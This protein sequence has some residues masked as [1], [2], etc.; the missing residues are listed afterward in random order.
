MKR[1]PADRAD[2]HVSAQVAAALAHLDATS[3]AGELA[4]A[5][6]EQDRVF[7]GAM[8]ELQAVRD[9][10]GSPENILGRAATKHGEIGCPFTPREHG[11]LGG[12]G[13]PMQVL[14]EMRG[15]QGVDPRAERNQAALG[16]LLARAP[17]S[18]RPPGRSR[19]PCHPS[20]RSHV[21]RLFTL[22]DPDRGT[23]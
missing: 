22:I 18:K 17:H 2:L 12:E 15:E 19:R 8:R 20:H 10:V 16:E 3:R 5:L 4:G 13:L 1:S 23:S 14:R 6:Q 11:H 21:N 7:L 9:F